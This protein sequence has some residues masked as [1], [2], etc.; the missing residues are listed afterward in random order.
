VLG[1]SQLSKKMTENGLITNQVE[2]GRGLTDPLPA[3]NDVWVNNTTGKR[4]LVSSENQAIAR[5][6]G[7]DLVVEFDLIFIPTDHV[8]Y[9][10]EVD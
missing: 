10:F 2:K 9:T 4:Y 5:L 1:G 7:V 3:P 8:V 6:R